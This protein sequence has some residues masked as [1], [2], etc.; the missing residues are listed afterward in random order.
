MTRASTS[1]SRFEPPIPAQATTQRVFHDGLVALLAAPYPAHLA[2]ALSG[3][4]DS[5]ALTLLAQEWATAHGIGVVALTV[6]H[7]L[8]E[9]ST[10]EAQHVANLMRDHGITHH[11]L[12]PEHTPAGNNLMQA[13]RTWRYDALTDF[14]RAHT[15]SHCLLGQHLDDQLETVALAHARGRDTLDLTAERSEGE[16]GMRPTRLYRGVKFLRPL[17]TFPKRDL[18]AYLR[19]RHVTWVEDP[20]NTDPRFARVRMREQ[21]AN[22]PNLAH[23]LHSTLA[24]R[25]AARE[26]RDAALAEAMPSCVHM[27]GGTATLNLS[28]WQSLASELR[29]LLLANLIRSIGGK[30]HRPRRHETER[31]V[32]ALLGEQQGKR[33]LGHCVISW[34]NGT[35]TI[36]PEPRL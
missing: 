11:I 26:A 20:T 17:L 30:P 3:G 24:A 21:L 13:A 9:D 2:I 14:C 34:K 6:D 33:T 18:I 15:I 36:R 5:L 28:Q 10:A 4:A 23:A 32:Q 12:T 25:T 7:R 35:A 19:A 27:L 16:A 1:S 8:R 22:D 29:S 31:L